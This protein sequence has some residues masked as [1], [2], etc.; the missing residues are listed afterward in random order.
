MDINI[1]ILNTEDIEYVKQLSEDKFNETLQIAISIG[2]KSIQMSEVN[3]NCHSYI[4]P[5]KEIV[6][7]KTEENT[8]YLLGI[9]DKLDD[10]LHIKTNSSRK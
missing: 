3:M 10:L 5:I 1:Q 7:E 6:R 9:S 8:E 2:L 4:D